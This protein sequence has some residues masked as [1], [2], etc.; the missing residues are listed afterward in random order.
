MTCTGYVLPLSVVDCTIEAVFVQ[1]CGRRTDA[2]R[3]LLCPAASRVR[4]TL[5]CAADLVAGAAFRQVTFHRKKNLQ[6]HEISAKSNYNYEKPFLYLARKLVGCAPLPLL[7]QTT[8]KPTSCLSSSA[9]MPRCGLRSLQS[10]DVFCTSRSW[11]DTLPRVSL[12]VVAGTRTCTSW[13]RWLC[14]RPRSWSTCSSSR[15]GLFEPATPR[16]T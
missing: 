7:L 1:Q 11:G 12:P 13:S 9:L 4:I 3:L 5:A 15:C 8:C 14:G 2:G 6:Y 10:S 16:R